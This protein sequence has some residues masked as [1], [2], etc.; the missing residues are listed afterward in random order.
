MGD[1]EG[2][3][4]QEAEADLAQGAAAVVPIDDVHHVRVAVDAV[5]VIEDDEMGGEAA[6]EFVVVLFVQVSVVDI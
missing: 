3:F 6:F 4:F 2:Y 5:N 1:T